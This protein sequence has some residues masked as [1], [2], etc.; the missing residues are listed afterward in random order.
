MGAEDKGYNEEIV[1]MSDLHWFFMKV[2]KYNLRKMELRTIFGESKMAVL[3]E[4]DKNAHLKYKQLVYVEFLEFI[5]RLAVKLFE[6][7]EYE[8][9]Q[10]NEKIEL[11]LDEIFSH[12]GYKRVKQEINIEVFSDSDS[13][14]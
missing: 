4:Q 6:N 14:Y 2:L 3:N 10:M 13:D 5:A 1:V 8:D 9:K 12:F 11:L 7:S